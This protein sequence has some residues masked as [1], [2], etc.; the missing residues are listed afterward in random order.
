MGSAGTKRELDGGE[1]GA[2]VSAG[3]ADAGCEARRGGDGVGMGV[4]HGFSTRWY[5]ERDPDAGQGKTVRERG[6]G[7]VIGRVEVTHSKS[8]DQAVTPSERD[9]HASLIALAPVMLDKLC[10]YWKMRPGSVMEELWSST[11]HPTDA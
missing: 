11:S 6:S 3:G 2:G 9:F 4:G 10:G 8:P 7:R 5:V 1:S